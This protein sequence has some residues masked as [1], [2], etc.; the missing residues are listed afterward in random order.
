MQP[1]KI[2]NIINAQETQDGDGVKIFRSIGSRELID[3]NP[4]LLLDELRSDKTA[5][6]IGGFPSHP[7][8]GFETITYL[9][10][11]QMRH[12][13]SEGNQGVISAGGLQWM[14]AGS[15]IIHSE[16]PEVVQGRLWGFQFWLNLPAEQKMRAPR[17]QE[18]QPKEIPEL[19]MSNGVVRVL[20]GVVESGEQ[21]KIQG[22]I[23]DIA[24]R[25]TLLDV[26]LEEGIWS[27]ELPSTQVTLVYAYS[28]SLNIEEVVLKEQQLAILSDGDS[29]RINVNDA[30]F[31]ALI[32]SADAIHEPIARSGPFV[33]N[34]QE[35]LLQAYHDYRSGHFI[36]R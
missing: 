26:Q 31:G 5:D 21:K 28:G 36:N 29:V 8:R 4:F 14:T 20:A 18:I 30:P 10:S 9:L 13:D 24:T 15:G 22:V 16:M 25:P 1:K 23:T 34:T 32:L 19:I 6:Y 11:G 7:H 35:E 12:E 27:T 33:M 17:Y 3:I 2:I